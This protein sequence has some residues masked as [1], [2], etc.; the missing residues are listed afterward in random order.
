MLIGSVL[1][2]AGIALIY[3][4]MPDKNGESPRFLRFGQSLV[5]YPPLILVLLGLG[6]AEFVSSVL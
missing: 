3:V 4:G 1:I 2:A 5:L 6:A